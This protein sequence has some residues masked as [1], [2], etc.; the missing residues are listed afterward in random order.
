MLAV[1]ALGILLLTVRGRSLLGVGLLLGYVGYSATF[2]WHAMTHDYYQVPL[3]PIIAICLAP[4]AGAVLQLPLW[5]RLPAIARGVILAGALAGACVV[6]A[7]S[8]PVTRRR[9][10]EQTAQALEVERLV[11]RGGRVLCLTDEYGYPL[12]VHGWLVMRPWPNIAEKVVE[13]LMAGADDDDVDRLLAVLGSTSTSAIESIPSAVSDEERLD[14]LLAEFR[15]SHFVITRMDELSRQ[16]DLKA[17]L[18]RR[19]AV[20]CD[21]KDLLIY[22]L[23]RPAEPAVGG[24]GE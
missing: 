18:A 4:L 9:A 20:V 2:T 16:R 21:R 7:E 10:P 12:A 8:Q 17:L 11:G 13:A 1:A 22:D 19:Y 14:R 3:I 5:D 23:G 6:A 15:P 24:G